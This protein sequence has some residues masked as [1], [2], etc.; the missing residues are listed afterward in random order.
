M[1][2]PK[3]VPYAVFEIVLILLLFFFFSFS[4]RVK[5]QNL[6]RWRVLHYFIW[7]KGSGTFALSWGHGEES[8]GSCDGSTQSSEVDV[9][10]HGAR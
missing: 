1:L 3:V 4:V 6:L 7:S 2:F 8:Q 9:V 5:I 10:A